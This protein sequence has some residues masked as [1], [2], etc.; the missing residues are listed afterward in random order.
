MVGSCGTFSSSVFSIHHFAFLNILSLAPS[1]TEILYALGA[2]PE[3]VGVTM[4]CDAPSEARLQPKV[5]GWTNV[6]D[7][8]MDRFQPDLIV[9]SMYLPPQV[10]ELHAKRP[11]LFCHV[12]PRT[13][14]DVYASITTIGARINRSAESEALV[15]RMRSEFDALRLQAAARPGV[16][17]YIEEWS[18]PP[19]ASGNWVPEVAAAVGITQTVIAPGERSREFAFRDLEAADPDVIILSICGAGDRVP[20]QQVSSRLGWGVLRAV[21]ENRIVVI[22]DSLLNRPGPRLTDGARALMSAMDRL[23][24]TR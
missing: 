11:E 5:G 2:G 24:V 8:L 9:T 7:D 16:H 10:R 12:E 23:R 6:Y 20:V 21:R 15:R 14:E 13:L 3:V 1:N 19:M 4:F 22:D 18:K 17:A